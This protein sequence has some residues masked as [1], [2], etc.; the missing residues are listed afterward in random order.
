MKECRLAQQLSSFPYILVGPNR[1]AICDGCD[2]G[3]EFSGS[4]AFMALI[5]LL[6]RRRGTALIFPSEYC[7]LSRGSFSNQKGT[8]YT[9]S[10]WQ[11]NTEFQLKNYIPISV[12]IN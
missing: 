9:D 8:C 3:D 11:N 1:R 10:K 12:A 4:L 5:L 2:N 6:W 7:C